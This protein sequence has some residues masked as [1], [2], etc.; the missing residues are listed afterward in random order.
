M[1]GADL[2]FLIV[3]AGLGAIVWELARP[4]LIVPGV[5]GAGG[6]AAGI[7]FAGKHTPQWP[8][9]VCLGLAALLFSLELLCE[10]YSLAGVFGTVAFFCGFYGLFRR[11]GGV[12]AW[13]AI[14]LSAVFG[15]AVVWLAGRTRRA[16]LNKRADA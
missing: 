6:V 3:M 11:P 16:R 7:Y 9:V 2:T 15:I 13:L 1:P 8:G 10:T 4:G 12:D 5:L 14:P